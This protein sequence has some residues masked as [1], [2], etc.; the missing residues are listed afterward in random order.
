MKWGIEMTTGQAKSRIRR[1]RLSTIIILVLLVLATLFLNFLGWHEITITLD[2][3]VESPFSVMVV[4]GEWWET[5][6][7]LRQ[8]SEH[9]WPFTYLSRELQKD[10][11][12]DNSHWDLT[13]GLAQFSPML[14]L[15]NL[16]ICLTGT[17]VIVFL[18]QQ[19][20]GEGESGRN[21]FQWHIKDFLALVFIVTLSIV[22]MRGSQNQFHDQLELVQEF[23]DHP[24]DR[25]DRPR[26]PDG[27]I[28]LEGPLLIR[29]ILGG[30]YFDRFDHAIVVECVP[31]ERIC[32]LGKVKGLRAVSIEGYASSGELLYLRKL[33]D[34]EALELS[35]GCYQQT[36]SDVYEEIGFQL[37][38]LP[39]LKQLSLR[40]S[41]FVEHSLLKIPTI[42]SLDLTST[43]TN[44]K[45]LKHLLNCSRIK[46]LG[47]SDTKVTEKGI[48]TVSELHSLKALWLA[49]LAIGDEVI[50]D[51]IK[52]KDLELLD[53]TLNNFTDEGIEA[54]QAKLP[55]CK[56]VNYKVPHT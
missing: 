4:E 2:T 42:E 8:Y 23:V 31:I 55:R 38:D 28:Q 53:V 20:K 15:L 40:G 12:T 14:L 37:P 39:N 25:F 21:F 30:E 18:I 35:Y 44:D 19:R 24:S 27:A 54:L 34:L 7:H 46:A 51:L 50:P 29:K 9:G 10:P 33:P 32:E 6:F 11:I 48:K 17:F 41:S 5:S 52:L 22:W 56:I 45:T 3:G 16:L 47:L 49:D 43:E 1:I 26:I 36:E 13:E